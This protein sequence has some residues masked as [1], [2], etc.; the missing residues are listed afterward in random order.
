MLW[1]QE[2]IIANWF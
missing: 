2:T 1:Q